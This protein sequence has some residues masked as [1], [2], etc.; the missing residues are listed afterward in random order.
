MSLECVDHTILLK[1]GR[2][3]KRHF[4]GCSGFDTKQCVWV[5]EIV[6]GMAKANFKVVA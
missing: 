2:Y 4:W 6:S 5:C 3:N 1:Q